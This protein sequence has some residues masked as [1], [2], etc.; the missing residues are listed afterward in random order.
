MPVAGRAEQREK[1]LLEAYL[2]A[3]PDAAAIEG[4]VAQV[5]AEL[6][7][8]GMRDMGRVMKECNARLPG[9][10]GKELSAAVKAKL[11]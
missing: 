2:P 4:V 7:A 5:I 11:A 9:A 6:G 8:S 10:A 1:T 3:A